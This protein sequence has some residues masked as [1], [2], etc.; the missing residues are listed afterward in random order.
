[1]RLL[2]AGEGDN[3][4]ADVEDAIGG[5]GNDRIAAGPVPALLR[6]GGG[7]DSIAGGPGEDRIEGEQGD[8]VIDA[9][10]GRYDSIDC[11]PGNDTLFADPGDFAAECEIAPDRD[12][13]G[14]LN[15]ADCAPDNA[16]VNP[17]AAEIFGNPVDEDCKGGPSYFQV[18]ATITYKLTTRKSPARVRFTSLRLSSLRAGDRVE[19]RCKTKA[20]GCAFA[21]K[22]QTVKAGRLTLSLTSLFKR[23]YL[24]RGAVVEIRVV[25]ANYIGRV[26]RLT[27]G[28][29][30]DVK[31]TRRCLP[32]GGTKVGPCPATP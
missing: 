30:A 27:V 3:V 10:D 8:D 1:M 2:K 22:K 28:R 5:S 32:V 19:T 16:A 21:V 15:E 25:R 29:R 13:D 6:G 12:G 24:R 17:N 18:G 7:N 14:F 31:L 9:R 11:G 23:R 26:L 4:A 20:R